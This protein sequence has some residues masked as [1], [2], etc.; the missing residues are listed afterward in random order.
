LFAT[1]EGVSFD[2]CAGF[3]QTCTAKLQVAAFVMR[4]RRDGEGYAGRGGY[5]PP[6]GLVG[7]EAGE[8]S[9]WQDAQLGQIFRNMRLAMKVSRE[10]IA[11][12]LA[13]STVCVDNFEAGAVAALPHA[14]ETDRIVRGYCELL[15]LDPEPILWRIRSGMQALTEQARAGQPMPL[16]AAIVPTT[17]SRS[18][19]RSQPV[20]HRRPTTGERSTPQFAQ[21][22]RTRALFA[23]S[24]PVALLAALVYVAHAAPRPVYRA[25][26]LL[27][28]PAG[29]GVR[30]VLDYVVLLTAPRREGLRWIEIG[31]PRL[32]KADK[33]VT[34]R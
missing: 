32:R 24:A 27:P 8:A 22:R 14:K 25:I 1:G 21:R 13:T 20:T 23:L 3:A 11:R 9:G 10:T 15:R 31:D 7:A 26:A 6:R 18:G 34:T 28:R 29:Q 12:R 33:L 2:N 19:R 5:S 16:P 4:L 17:A 30:A